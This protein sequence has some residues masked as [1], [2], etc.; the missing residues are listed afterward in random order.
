MGLI[1]TT[2]GEPIR[3]LN[4]ET[5]LVSPDN[6]K[7][8]EVNPRQGDVGAL[9]VSFRENGFYGAV[10]VDKRDGR[11][12]AG[13]HRVMAARQLGMMQI[14]VQYVKTDGDIHALRVLLADNRHSDIASYDDNVLAELL[15]TMNSDDGLL[16]TGYSTHDVENLVNELDH[17]WSDGR[18]R[19][20]NK[21]KDNV[22]ARPVLTVAEVRIFEDALSAT[23]EINR[24]DA[25][26]ILCKS[27]LNTC[28]KKTTRV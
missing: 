18:G 16:G 1:E 22:T 24:A 3:L 25:L 21:S 7:L 19:T 4:L 13:N 27:Y 9:C 12:L 14:P 26:M 15:Q 2:S 10:V 5:A 28:Q 8:N 17:D 6:V 23:G 20:L 11:V